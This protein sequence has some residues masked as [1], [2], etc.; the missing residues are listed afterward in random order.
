M[1]HFRARGAIVRTIFSLVI[2]IT[3]IGISIL[4]ICN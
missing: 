4:C 3:T 2:I 1:L